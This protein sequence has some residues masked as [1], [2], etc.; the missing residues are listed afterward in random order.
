MSND[1]QRIAAIVAYDGTAFHGWQRQRQPEVATVQAALEAALSRVADQ[2]VVVQCAG[3]TDAGVHADAQVVH[4]DGPSRALAAWVR[5]GNS[6]LPASVRVR[7]AHAVPD[8]FHARFSATARRYR[9]L[10]YNHAQPPAH[11]YS[12]VTWIRQPLDS[13][14]MHRAAQD[15]LGERDFS[16]FR[17]AQCDAN[18]PM[19]NV[20]QIHVQRRGVLIVV[21]IKANAFLHHMVR[22]IVGVLLPIGRGE[23]PETWAAEVLATGDRTLAGVTARPEGLYL[24]QVDYP[25]E[26]GLPELDIGPW[27]LNVVSDR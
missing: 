1:N 13:N 21:D 19:R 20:M 2:P 22:N 3:R 27:F 9:Y 25:G 5:G 10:I 4:F 23:Q 17:S 12:G 14:A 8:S 26:F 6:H 18:T 15:L 24:V 11:G 7:A 16:A